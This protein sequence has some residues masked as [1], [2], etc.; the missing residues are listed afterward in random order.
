MT[1]LQ[2]KHITAIKENFPEDFKSNTKIC[3]RIWSLALANMGIEMPEEMLGVMM[4][5]KP[6]H[7]TRMRRKLYPSTDDQY[8]TEAKMRNQN[9]FYE[10]YE[11]EVDNL[12]KQQGLI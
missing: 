4:R 2:P 12:N 7:I 3:H 6:E 11:E 9:K 5:Y 1:S 8:K 10:E